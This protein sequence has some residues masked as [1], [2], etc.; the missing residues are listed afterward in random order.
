MKTGKPALAELLWLAEDRNSLPIRVYNYRYGWSPDVPV[1][2]I[3]VEEFRER[4][5]GIW[6]PARMTHTKYGPLDSKGL[7]ERQWQ[8]RATMT[9]ADVSIAPDFPV[10]HFSEKGVRSAAK[11]SPAKG[12]A[13]DPSKEP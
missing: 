5:P 8:W 11:P 7:G 12:A 2:Q 6:L 1:S 4:S 9:I 3:S 13:Q 10:E